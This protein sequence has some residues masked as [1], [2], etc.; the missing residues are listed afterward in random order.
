MEEDTGIDP[1]DWYWVNPIP[2]QSPW[3]EDG[4]P[5]RVEIT[6]QEPM[7]SNDQYSLT[8]IIVVLSQLYFK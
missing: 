8:K 7:T 5:P 2:I 3:H 1:M 6:W 4:A